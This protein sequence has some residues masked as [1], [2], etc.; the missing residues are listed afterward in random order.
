MDESKVA[1]WRTKTLE[2]VR[3][4]LRKPPTIE[5]REGAIEALAFVLATIWLARAGRA[6]APETVETM[7]A[8]VLATLERETRT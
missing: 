8:R 2:L 3:R 7:A 1:Y 4:V 6:Y 5:A